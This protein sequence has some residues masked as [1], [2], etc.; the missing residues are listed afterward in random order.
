MTRPT[1]DQLRLAAP[2]LGVDLATALNE[3]WGV[4]REDL[5]EL[6]NASGYAA[7]PDLRQYLTD[8][9]RA[10][11]DDFALYTL[12]KRNTKL[13]RSLR[14]QLDGRSETR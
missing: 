7:Q 11:V 13:A 4:T 5:A 1:P 12:A 8:E 2:L 6:Q 14:K 10:A 9:E 3:V